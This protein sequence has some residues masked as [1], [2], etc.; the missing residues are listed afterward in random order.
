MNEDDL[1]HAPLFP[2]DVAS[3]FRS[4][5]DV[6]Q[7]GLLMTV[8]G[9]SHDGDELIAQVLWGVTRFAMPQLSEE[10]VCRTLF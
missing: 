6:I 2:K 9:P 7:K 8:G 3:E 10:E 5:W 4:R 1:Q